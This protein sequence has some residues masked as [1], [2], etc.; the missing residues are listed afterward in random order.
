MHQT[1]NLACIDN[2]DSINN[3][4][5]NAKEREQVDTSVSDT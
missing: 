5:S 2:G 4:D 3:N 1:S